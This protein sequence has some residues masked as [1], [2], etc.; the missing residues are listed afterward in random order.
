MQENGQDSTHQSTENQQPDQGNE[1]SRSKANRH[2]G[3]KFFLGLLTVLIVAS[4]PVY[5]W[6]SNNRSDDAKTNG[7]TKSSSSSSSKHSSD[8]SSSES[9]DKKDSKE[10]SS[11]SEADARSS[12]AA[13]SSKAAD[14][15]SKAAAEESSK[16]AA[17][18]SSAAAS[19]ANAN[20]A[21]LS[22]GQTLYNF[23][24][25][26]GSTTQQII[27]LNPGVTVN[28]Y[29]QYAGQELRIR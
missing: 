29:S 25:S 11:Q 20:T 16:Q 7:I 26:H 3:L 24:I 23:A 21:V 15:S 1:R 9:K 28:N 17:D 8:K 18:A 10:D 5:G 4:V 2:S 13:A 19:A 14:A 6:A 22:P 12:E 27:N